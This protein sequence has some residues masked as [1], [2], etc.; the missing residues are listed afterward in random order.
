MTSPSSPISRLP[1]ARIIASWTVGKGEYWRVLNEVNR[2]RAR[3][4]LPIRTIVR[5]QRYYNA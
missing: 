4:R 3:G 5:E 2:N 1:S